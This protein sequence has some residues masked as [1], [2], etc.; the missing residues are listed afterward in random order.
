MISFNKKSICTE[1]TCVG[2]YLRGTREEQGLT[3]AEV[4]K[5]IGIK[6]NYL[7]YLEEGKYDCLPGKVYIK[8]F[9]KKYA[10]FLKL[11]VAKVVRKCEKECTVD[12]HSQKSNLV[13]DRTKEKHYRSTFV[14]S[15]FLRNAV[16]VVVLLACLSYLG[17]KVTNILL[18]P[19]LIIENPAD[20]TIVSENQI[21]VYGLTDKEVKVVINDDEIYSDPDGR[22]EKMVNLHDGLNKITISAQKKHGRARVEVRRVLVDKKLSV[23]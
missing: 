16:V 22:F 8:S 2:D 6:A 19:D 5:E 10:G 11:D 3:L 1:Y 15:R 9:L 12:T 7:G 20:N 17:F 14:L 18:P 4:A 13:Y 23:N 21:E